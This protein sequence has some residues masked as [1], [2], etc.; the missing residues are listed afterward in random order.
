MASVA[1]NPAPVPQP[2]SRRKSILDLAP[3]ELDC[4]N[5]L[6]PLGEATVREVQAAISGYRPRAYTTIMTIL[7][8]LARK[9]VV[10]RRK[11]GRAYLY[12]ANL[13]A[14]AA[15]DAAVERLVTAFFG[16]SRQALAQHIGIAANDRRQRSR[17]N[18][19][20]AQPFRAE[21]SAP[22]LSGADEMPDSLD[23]TLL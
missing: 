3:L 12:R 8:R 14:D 17:E 6:W 21:S 20:A 19:A 23:E 5:A 15:R 9:G 11:I 10:A 16:G 2:T 18:A 4:M 7:D 13:M 22:V 1:K